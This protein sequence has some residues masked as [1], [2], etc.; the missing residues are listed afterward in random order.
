M[1][2]LAAKL[3][4]KDRITKA[5]KSEPRTI[6]ELASEL[7]DDVE[8][9]S[10]MLCRYSGSQAKRALFTRPTDTPDGIQRWALLEARVS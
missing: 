4:L 8:T 2:S 3:P 1:D 9:V 6:A 10:R 5:V 7:D